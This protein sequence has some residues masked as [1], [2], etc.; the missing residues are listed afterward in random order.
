M[1]P[2]AARITTE[3]DFRRIRRT[4]VTGHGDFVTVRTIPNVPARYGF[5]AGLR[6]SKQATVRNTVKRRLREAVRELEPEAGETVII[7]KPAAA[8][9]PYADLKDDLTAV[10]AKIKS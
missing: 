1:L 7:A 5:V 3:A 6:V 10:F 4:G 8:E 9:T 2:V